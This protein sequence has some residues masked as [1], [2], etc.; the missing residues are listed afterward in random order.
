MKVLLLALAFALVAT[1]AGAQDIGPVRPDAGASA[2][3]VQTTDPIANT[4]YTNCL[5][6]EADWPNWLDPAVHQDCQTWDPDT[7]TDHNIIVPRGGGDVVVRAVTVADTGLISNLSSNR[8]TV[9]DVPFGPTL[10]SDST[11]ATEATGMED[12]V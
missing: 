3:R 10:L 2:T 6:I 4:S 9:Q 8:K 12:V 1:A 11:E 5:V 7:I